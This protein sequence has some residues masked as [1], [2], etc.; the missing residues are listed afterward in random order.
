MTATPVQTTLEERVL[1]WTEQ[2]CDS[3]AEN[4]KQYHLRSM[5]RMNADSGS[6]YSRKEIEATENGTANLMKF[7]IQ[8]GKKYYKIIQQDFDTFRDRNEYQV[9]VVFMPL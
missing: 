9:M 4:Y 5:K 1:E 7:R 6:E 8:K 2:L 3:L